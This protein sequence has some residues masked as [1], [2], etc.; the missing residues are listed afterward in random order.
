MDIILLEYKLKSA[1]VTR[2]KLNETMGWSEGTR[3]TR[4]LRGENWLVS[5]AA[6]LL[7]LGLTWE[8]LRVIFF[9][10]N[11]S[12]NRQNGPKKVRL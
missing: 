9:T 2:R 10:E 11:G 12:K 8:D 6:K 4:C 3:Q 7:S 1:G 5:E